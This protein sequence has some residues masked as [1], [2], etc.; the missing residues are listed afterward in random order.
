MLEEALSGLPQEKQET[1]HLV[2]KILF[3]LGFNDDLLQSSPSCLSGGY[4]LRLKLAKVLAKEPNC[5]LLDEPTNY[6]DIE[7]IDWL[8]SHLK[9]WKGECILV[10]HDRSFIDAVVSSVM[11]IYRKKLKKHQGT[12]EHFYQKLLEE[13]ELYE[14][15]QVQLEKKKE[16]LERFIHRF[17]AKASK[18]SQARSKEK[19]LQKIPTLAKLVALESL[20]F[21]F[22]YAPY[23]GKIQAKAQDLSFGYEGE[24]KIIKHLSF[25]I[26][27]GGRIAIIGKNGRGKSTLLRLLS[28]EISPVLGSYK[29]FDSVQIGYFG[30]T[31]MTKLDPQKTIE[32]EIA[33]ANRLL[34]YTEVKNLCGQMCFPSES[35]QKKIEVLSGGEKSR[36]L[37]GKILATPTNLLLLDEPTHHLDMESVEAFIE[38][39]NDYPGAVVLV[40]HSEWMLE[41]FAPTLLI[42]FEEEGQR[43]FLGT[44]AEFLEKGGWQKPASCKKLPKEVQTLDIRALAK[45]KKSLQS[46]IASLEQTIMSKEEELA[47]VEKLLLD[48]YEQGTHSSLKELTLQSMFLREEIDKLYLH[49]EQIDQELSSFG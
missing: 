30:Q 14:K 3:G 4:H 21:S 38:A 6:L 46:K 49:L 16:H 41:A 10:S 39:T 40:T 44:Y 2:E 1:P 42:L 25:E 33:S 37:L 13:E 5:L 24:P 20:A 17:G 34:S 22:T 7:S 9:R 45:A 36:V 27:K 48:C 35:S 18:A 19:A 31:H 28:Q 32:E 8:I 26:E 15:T 47:R 29:L 23:P 12:T 43:I 11:G